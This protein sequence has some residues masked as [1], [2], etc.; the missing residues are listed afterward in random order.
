M[1]TLA[2]GGFNNI[3]RSPLSLIPSPQPR[4]VAVCLE[5]V[6][7]GVT[8]KSRSVLIGAVIHDRVLNH[9]IRGVTVKSRSVFLGDA[10][11]VLS[12][13]SGQQARDCDD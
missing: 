13:L 7:R 12:Q 4:E 5:A 10:W 6:S 8:V 1:F 9:L 3:M 11:I 2:Q